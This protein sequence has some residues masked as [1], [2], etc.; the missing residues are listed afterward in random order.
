MREA[1]IA[2]G[3]EG[4]DSV[5]TYGEAS[6]QASIVECCFSNDFCINSQKTFDINHDIKLTYDDLKN[7]ENKDIPAHD[8]LCAGFPCQP[9]S[10]AGNQQ[11]F[12]DE[13]SNIF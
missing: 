9:F 7:I 2:A 5:G 1:S 8:I 11:G 3:R 4:C 13:R 6:S 12:R 10:I